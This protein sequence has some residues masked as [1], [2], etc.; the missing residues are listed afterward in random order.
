MK[1]TSV[2]FTNQTRPQLNP[3]HLT[4]SVLNNLVR[5]SS[6][7]TSHGTHWKLERV[8]AMSLL[9]LLPISIK[10]EHPIADYLI[11]AALITHSTFGLKMIV[12]DYVHGPTAPKVGVALVYLLSVVAFAGLCY[13]NYTDIGVIKAVKK[14]W[15][16]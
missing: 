2:L 14:L 5:A 12:T 1:K 11:S 9:L 6:S 3:V 7:S 13:F 8:L 15:T 4:Q 16:L 10:S